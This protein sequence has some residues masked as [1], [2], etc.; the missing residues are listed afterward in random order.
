MGLQLLDCIF[1]F[2]DLQEYC[3]L[4]IFLDKT[5]HVLLVGKIR[6]NLC[7]EVFK[8]LLIVSVELIVAVIVRTTY[9]NV[10]IAAA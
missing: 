10:S 7:H 6:S 2:R 3:A 5:Y 1:S 9:I 8:V 4:D